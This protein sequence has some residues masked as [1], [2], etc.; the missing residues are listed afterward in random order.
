MEEKGF[1]L[2][3]VA[4]K[5]VSTEVNAQFCAINPLSASFIGWAVLKEPFGIRGLIGAA[6]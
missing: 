1:T 2:Q 4:K 3:P 5:Y 6:L